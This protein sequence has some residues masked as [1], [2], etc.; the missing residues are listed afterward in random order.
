MKTE[1][2]FKTYRPTIPEDLDLV[3]DLDGIYKE[4]KESGMTKLPPYLNSFTRGERT[5]RL[6]M[7]SLIKITKIHSYARFDL[8]VRGKESG[9]YT[10]WPSIIT[11]V[12]G[13]PLHIQKAEEL[14]IRY[15]EP[16]KNIII[17]GFQRNYA[18]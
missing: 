7:G 3:M 18:E 16:R 17:I 6:V 4:W 12:L 9:I 11:F 5:D 1:E 2:A 14:I 13:I 8:Y 15:L 10:H